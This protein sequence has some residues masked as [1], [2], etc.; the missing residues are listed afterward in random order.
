MFAVTEKIQGKNKRIPVAGCR[1]I[2]GNLLRDRYFKLVRGT[3][4]LYT[5]KLY[6]LKHFKDE[7]PEIK[8]GMEC[9]LALDDHEVVIQEGDAILC[10]EEFQTQP[11]VDWELPF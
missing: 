3:N 10:Y 2:R 5:G 4:L 6:M 1:C 9:G 7:V 8:E 11:T